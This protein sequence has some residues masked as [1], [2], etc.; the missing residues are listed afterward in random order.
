MFSSNLPNL[1]YSEAIN[2]FKILVHKSVACFSIAI[3]LIIS[4]LHNIQASRKPGHNIL[5]KLPQQELGA[6]FGYKRK[7]SLS[8]SGCRYI[9]RQESGVLCGLI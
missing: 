5:E 6:S 4:S 3:F 2:W 1:Q 9:S 8:P 7:T